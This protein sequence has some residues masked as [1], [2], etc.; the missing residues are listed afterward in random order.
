MIVKEFGGLNGISY[1]KYIDK[2]QSS[3][4][5]NESNFLQS[6]AFAEA[7]YLTLLKNGLKPEQARD[8]LPLALKTEL[9]MTGFIS[10]CIRYFNYTIRW[11]CIILPIPLYDLS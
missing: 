4:L 8:V 7:N 11:F 1:H 6:I 10:D 9:V 3:E 5:A 2:F